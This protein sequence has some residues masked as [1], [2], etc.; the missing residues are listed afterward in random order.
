MLVNFFWIITNT[1]AGGMLEA[2]CQNFPNTVRIDYPNTNLYQQIVILV[3]MASMQGTSD[4]STSFTDA[5]Y[6]WY[7]A[8]MIYL[9]INIRNI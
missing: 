5:F 6:H 7:P 9:P 1:Q 4:A 2:V 3:N 8:L